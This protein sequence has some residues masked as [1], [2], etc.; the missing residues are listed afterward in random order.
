MPLYLHPNITAYVPKERGFRF[1][2]TWLRE[3][4]CVNVVKKGWEFTEGRHI[5]DKLKYCG[6]QLQRGETYNRQIEVLWAATS[7][8]GRGS[9]QGVQA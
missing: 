7:G 6:L 3:K 8:M 5:I 2:N 9:S 4:E 1:E